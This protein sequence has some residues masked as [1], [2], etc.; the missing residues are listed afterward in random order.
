MMIV[1]A[2][3]LTFRE[4]NWN[5]KDNLKKIYKNSSNVGLD[6]HFTKL[7][8]I[9]ITVLKYFTRK[10]MKFYEGNKNRDDG[11][12]LN[13]N[14]Q[15]EFSWGKT[16]LKIIIYFLYSMEEIF[17]CF[18]FY[19]INYYFLKIIFTSTGFDKFKINIYLFFNF[20]FNDVNHY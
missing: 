18:F 15:V 16:N 11:G 9:I 13:F 20:F 5:F 12:I 2:R 14:T 4:M 1:S 3:R 6:E 10:K 19:I 8:E 17:F 7:C